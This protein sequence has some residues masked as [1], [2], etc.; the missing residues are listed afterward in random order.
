MCTPHTW[1]D[2]ADNV[3]Q[4]SE[5]TSTRRLHSGGRAEVGQ[6]GRPRWVG[7]LLIGQF[8]FLFVNGL[9]GT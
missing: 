7:H 1:S 6:I 9:T 4:A 5:R 2:P 8:D 3:V